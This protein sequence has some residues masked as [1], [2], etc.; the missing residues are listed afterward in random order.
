MTRKPIN[1]LLNVKPFTLLTNSMKI[2]YPATGRKLKQMITWLLK[3]GL[4]YE[5]HRMNYIKSYALMDN[6]ISKQEIKIVELFHK[7]EHKE[8]IEKMLAKTRPEAKIIYDL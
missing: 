4:V 3:S 5:I 2:T 8:K 1:R 7:P 6:K